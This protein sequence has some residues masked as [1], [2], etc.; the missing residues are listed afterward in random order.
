M[1]MGPSGATVVGIASVV[2]SYAAPPSPTTTSIAMAASFPTVKRFCSRT[3]GAM[4][5]AFTTLTPAIRRSASG[6]TRVTFR[7]TSSAR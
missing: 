2:P 7:P 1:A 5:I 3:P 6:F 4:P